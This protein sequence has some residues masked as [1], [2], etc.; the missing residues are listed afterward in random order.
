MNNPPAFPGKQ[1][2]LLI[3]SE[4]SDIAKEY[5]ID[6]NGMTL[7]DYFAAKAMQGLLSDP[8]WRQDMDFEETAHAAYKQADAMLKAG[9]A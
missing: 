1:K 7:R 6:Q 4:H 9:G 8:D 2:A 3:K 5:E